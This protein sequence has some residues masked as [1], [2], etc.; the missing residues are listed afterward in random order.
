MRFDRS[1][2]L[3]PVPLILLLM[4][5]LGAA[6]GQ[7]AGNRLRILDEE[8]HI[9]IYMAALLAHANRLVVSA[10]ET[11]DA[12]NRSP[13]EMCSPE[14]MAYLRDLIFSAYQIKDIGRFR[15]GRFI[16]STLLSNILDNPTVRLRMFI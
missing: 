14:D 1:K 2:F 6:F 16:C 13:Y 11:I 10:H 8:R 5:F 12:A 4:L 7:W 9:N 15:G 3:K